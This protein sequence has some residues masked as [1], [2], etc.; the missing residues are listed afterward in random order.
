MQDIVLKLKASSTDASKFSTDTFY[1]E[2]RI[3]E[4]T[5]ESIHLQDPI[6]TSNTI[7]VSELKL[8]ASSVSLS[9]FYN[10]H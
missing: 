6:N 5:P 10:M 7:S 4:I 9:C 2:K 8:T 3:A 1:Y